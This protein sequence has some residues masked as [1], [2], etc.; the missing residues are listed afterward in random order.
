MV[1]SSKPNSGFD[2]VNRL[3]VS[4]PPGLRGRYLSD[5]SNDM[6]KVT[7]EGLPQVVTV[8]KITDTAA[9]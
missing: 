3:I 4:L 9:L 7:P 5:T 8:G 2:I 6:E 1:L